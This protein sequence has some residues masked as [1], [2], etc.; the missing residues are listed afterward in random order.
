[1]YIRVLPCKHSST[2]ASMQ[3]SC[4]YDK[5]PRIVA[6]LLSDAAGSA[7]PAELLL[8]KSRSSDNLCVLHKRSD[9]WEDESAG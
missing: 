6:G 9:V 3:R 8:S 2:R 1:M 4:A 7:D 5:G